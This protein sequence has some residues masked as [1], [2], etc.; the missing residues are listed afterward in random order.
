[1]SQLATKSATA[2]SITEK[3]LPFI[4]DSYINRYQQEYKDDFVDKWDEIIDW[5]RRQE[6]EGS[7]FIKALHNYGVKRVLDV[8]TGTGFH[9]IQLLNAGFDV[10]SVDGSANMLTKAYKNAKQYGAQIKTAQ[11]DWRWL[12][13]IIH[14]KFDAIICLGNSFTHLFTEIDQKKSLTE[15]YYCLK[16]NGILIIDQ[17]NYDAILDAGFRVTHEHYYC[18]KSVTIQPVYIDEHLIRFC[19]AFSDGSQHHLNLNPLRSCKMMELLSGAGFKDQK[20][21]GDF[22]ETFHCYEPDFLINIVKK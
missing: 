14:E 4:S 22:K 18:G 1:M 13:R 11:A 2:H 16:N 10:V 19:Y 15:F 21:Y 12:S 5:R 17:R 8:A 3:S 6:S 20:T 7:F 9:S